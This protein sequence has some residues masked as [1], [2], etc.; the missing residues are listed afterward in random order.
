MPLCWLKDWLTRWFQNHICHLPVCWSVL[1][2]EVL[3]PMST[4]KRCYKRLGICPVAFSIICRCTGQPWDPK[5]QKLTFS[6]LKIGLPNRKV[7]FQP[8]ICRGELLVLGSVTTIW[9]CISHW[10]WWCSIVILVRWRVTLPIC[11]GKVDEMSDSR[12]AAGTP[13]RMKLYPH[14]QHHGPTFLATCFIS[15][16]GGGL[17]VFLWILFKWCLVTMGHCQISNWNSLSNRKLVTIWFGSAGSIWWNVRYVCDPTQFLGQSFDMLKFTLP[18][19]NIT[20]EN[21]WLEY[22]FPFG[23]AV[24]D[25]QTSIKVLV[26]HQ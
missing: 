10:R 8:S 19:T 22:L 5:H 2:L 24:L 16:L 23:M 3:I 18:E 13:A 12:H 6:P 14:H 11:G 4:S 15:F 17:V 20:P 25:Y 9:R 21:G 1:I 26:F 7:V